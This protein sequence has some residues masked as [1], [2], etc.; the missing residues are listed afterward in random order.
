M[1]SG[2]DELLL[3]HLRK[4]ARTPLTKMSRSTA[5]PVSTLFDRLKWNEEHVIVKHTSLLNFSALGYNARAN[6]TLR[7]DRHDK[8][9]VQQYLISHPAINAVYRINNGYDFMIEGIFR[10]VKDLEEFMEE[11]EAKFTIHDKKAFFIIED[12]KREAF[13]TDAG[14]KKDTTKL[15]QPLSIDAFASGIECH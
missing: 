14:S 7:V 4:N 3:V 10:Q 1:I 11:L 5:I 12:L 15:T 6:V 9:E 13:L 2:K 8:Q